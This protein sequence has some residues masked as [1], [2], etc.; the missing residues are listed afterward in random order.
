MAFTILM[1]FPNQL[2]FWK[3][4]DP[5]FPHETHKQKTSFKLLTIC[6]ANVHRISTRINPRSEDCKGRW[7]GAK[8]DNKGYESFPVNTFCPTSPV[9][10]PPKRPCPRIC[11]GDHPLR[12]RMTP[13]AHVPLT[14]TLG[15][16]EKFTEAPSTTSATHRVLP[17]RETQY[18][19]Y[20]HLCPA[21]R[22]E[23]TEKHEFKVRGLYRNTRKTG[24]EQRV[25]HKC[26]QTSILV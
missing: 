10:L 4:I 26:T 25:P 18:L 22:G 12:T 13:G 6:F 2:K 16:C 17:S 14:R 21:S 20:F 11:S 19:C 24:R 1:S 5:T 3:F 15:N 9:K 8:Q 23:C 7:V